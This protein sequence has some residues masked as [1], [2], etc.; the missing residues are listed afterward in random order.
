MSW[1]ESCDS[2]GAPGTLLLLP[3]K[4]CGVVVVQLQLRCLYSLPFL[5]LE[6]FRCH[7]SCTV[8]SRLQVLNNRLCSK[9]LGQAESRPPI[10]ISTVGK[11]EEYTFLHTSVGFVHVPS[12]PNHFGH[13]WY[14]GSY[15]HQA[16]RTAK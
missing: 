6:I 7:H 13:K 9:R 4:Y 11:F 2:A 1:S 3:T 15:H 5:D 12:C 16:Q 10:S 14:N 8:C